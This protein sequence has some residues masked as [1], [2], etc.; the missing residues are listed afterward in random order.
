M[1]LGIFLRSYKTYNGI[2]Y[3]PLSSNEK[4]NGIVG[5]NGVGKSS[6][7]EAIDCIFNQRKWNIN[8]LA[9]RS[10]LGTTKPYIIPVFYVDESIFNVETLP[11]AKKISDRVKLFIETDSATANRVHFNNFKNHLESIDFQDSKLLIP[12]GINHEFKIELGIFSSNDFLSKIFYEGITEL[13]SDNTQKL[14]SIL[15]T[16]TSSIDYIYI[17]KDIDPETFMKLER[18]E[19]QILMGEKL[20]DIIS[21]NFSERQLSSINDGLKD[22][23]NTL[24]GELVNYSY[25]TPHTR[26]QYLKKADV[27][28][29]IID[30]FFNIR[31]LH[32]KVNTSDWLELESLSSGEKQKAIIDV[33]DRLLNLHA[34]NGDNLIIA[35]DEPEASLHMSACFDQF[36]SLYKISDKCTQLFFTTHWYGFFPIIE[37]GFV[38][39]VNKINGNHLFDQIQLQRYQEQIKQQTILSRGILPYDIRLK[40]INDFVQSI[41][42]S[43]MMEDPFNWLFCEGSSEK[44][45]F[46]YYFKDLI[47]DKKLRIMPM[48]GVHGIKKLY[49]SII[50]PFEEFKDEI[51]GKIYM[52]TDTDEQLV[53]FDTKDDISNLVCKRLVNNNNSTLLVKLTSNPKS[54]KTEIEDILNGKK[55]YETLISFKE[56]YSD[57]LTFLEDNL[58]LTE[59]TAF[60]ELDLSPSKYLKLTEFYDHQNVK[61]EFAKKY[62]ELAEDT[63]IEPSAITKIKEFFDS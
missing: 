45:Y 53:E 51:K 1:I 10:G 19:I 37:N 35:I 24:T 46:E 27:Y 11:L 3:I 23:L 33:A 63:D 32:K 47:K 61:F 44:I 25:R 12:L 41:M 14:E 4:F 39:I 18:S 34:N 2:N 17:P 43:I 13:S 50:G 7:L 52:L 30:S 21:Q 26:Q 6:I 29:L 16:I 58:E 62:I 60:K 49:N 8:V 56:S 22:F 28:N 57:K 20:N 55:V 54:P 48:G 5:D 31:K 42:A 9:S 38:S 59:N 36:T 15:K 40:R